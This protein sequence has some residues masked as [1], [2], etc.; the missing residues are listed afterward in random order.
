MNISEVIHKIIIQKGLSSNPY[1]LQYISG[2][3]KHGVY[4]ILTKKEKLII[5]LGEELPP[6]IYKKEED[7]LRALRGTR[8]FAIPEV[9]ARGSMNG[10]QYILMT[11]LSEGKPNWK[12]F[13]IR[14]AE[15]HQHSS[16]QFGW[17]ED[18]YLA[19]LGQS[20]KWR[21]SWTDFYIH[22]RNLPQLELAKRSGFLQSVTMNMMTRLENWM[23]DNCPD[24]KPALL[25]GDLWNGNALFDEDGNPA[26]IDPAV[27]YGNS[28]MDLAMMQLFGGFPSETFDAYLLH[29]DLDKK[30]KERV[31]LY[32][33]YPLL[34]HLN[35]FGKS[36]ESVVSETFFKFK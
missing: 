6:E 33:L 11:F 2:G 22:E 12:E 36:Y 35:L 19:T 4:R 31:D 18:N 20:N 26:L 29:F 17:H 28:E 34:V 10:F 14:L 1:E 30:F 15:L 23:S 25:H 5:K 32:Q 8:T 27:Y 16:E 13:G 24:S 9:I 21:G 3:Q 7:G